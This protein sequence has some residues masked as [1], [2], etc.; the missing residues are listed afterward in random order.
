[1]KVE[2]GMRRFKGL[3]LASSNQ[4]EREIND[5]ILQNPRSSLISEIRSLSADCLPRPT[6]FLVRTADS[7]GLEAQSNAFFNT[8]GIQNL[9]QDLR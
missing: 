8:S 4:N 1:M 5:H 7:R 3:N 9:T 2:G 6:G